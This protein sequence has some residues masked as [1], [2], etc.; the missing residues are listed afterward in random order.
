MLP[1]A[2][3]GIWEAPTHRAWADAQRP[4]TRS[5][6]GLLLGAARQAGG[7][8]QQCQPTHLPN[9][10]PASSAVPRLPPPQRVHCALRL[11]PRRAEAP[12]RAAEQERSIP[13][14]GT[15]T[16]QTE[17]LRHR[18]TC[19]RLAK[20]AVAEPGAEPGSVPPPPAAVTG[21]LPVLFAGAVLIPLPAA[22]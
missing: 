11:L 10:N 6:P 17:T 14:C 1:P 18:E 5:C 21:E 8:G 13:S 4:A 19:P 16:Q 20:R 9:L 2:G 3:G 22:E 15:E 7:G 12:V